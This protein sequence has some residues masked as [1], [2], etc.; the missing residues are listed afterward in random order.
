MRQIISLYDT[1][2]L[3][4]HAAIKK[5]RAVKLPIVITSRKGQERYDFLLITLK[6]KCIKII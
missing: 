6:L 3:T 2:M 1:F 4:D 5:K